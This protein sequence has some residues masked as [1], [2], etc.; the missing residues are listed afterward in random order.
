M[1]KFQLKG[2]TAIVTGGNR[3]LGLGI[4]AALSEAGANVA[5]VSRGDSKEAKE[6]VEKNGANFLHIQADLADP[7][8]WQDVINSAVK[9]FGSIDIL[10]NNAG[11]ILRKPALDYTPEEWRQIMNVDLDAV[12]FLS[13]YA[14]KQFIKQGTPGKIISLSSLVAFHG[15]INT[16]PYTSAKTALVGL[17]K[18]MSNE[19]GKYNINVNAIA[20]GYMVT[21]MTEE[22]R[23]NKERSEQINKRIPLKRWGT[24]EDVGALVLFLASP[25]SDYISGQTIPVEGGWLGN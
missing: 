13:Q 23:N 7:S 10:V 4:T 15:A 24:P 19:W 21:D 3:G 20:P 2:K 16:A 11:I 5:V 12:F 14:A 22:L 6:I 8:C 17:T 9:H 25:A 1:E 18:L